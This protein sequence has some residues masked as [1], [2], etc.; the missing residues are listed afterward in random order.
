MRFSLK[1]CVLLFFVATV[2][3]AK[4]QQVLKTPRAVSP[5]AEVKQTIG[6]AEITVNY[7]RPK[8]TSPQGQDRTGKIWGQLVPYGKT[9]LGF[10][11]T[12]PAPWRAGAN[13]NTVFSISHD[14]SIQGK[15]LQA[16][17]YGL[18]I[19]VKEN[20]QATFI[21]NSDVD[22]WGSYFYKSENDVLTV[23]VATSEVA[24]TEV[25]TYNFI[26]FTASSTTLVLDWEKKRFPLKIEVA[27][28]EQVFVN[29]QKELNGLQGFFWRGYSEAALY[30]VQNNFHMEQAG[31]WIDRS[32]GIERNFTNLSVKA[33]LEEKRGN[34]AASATLMKEALEMPTASVNNY[35]AYGRQL[36]G[37]KQGAAA[38]D[39]YKKMN[40]RWPDHWLSP[41]GLARGYSATGDFKKALKYE[42][43]AYEKAP[44]GSKPFLEGYLKTLK[45][46]KDFN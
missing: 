38:L 11:G 18:H 34:D 32:L 21:F 22:A 6:I 8:V 31:I 2:Q 12:E 46:G 7:S 43:V 17:S 25:L 40:K 16:G 19:V 1:L 10:G 37:K 9:N 29:M 23:E 30:C 4:A 24:F 44:D 35:Y 20:N 36:I 39:I 28:A 15:L 45:E 14:V 26:D 33:Q 13:E 41:H 27:T 3:G 5:A 42:E